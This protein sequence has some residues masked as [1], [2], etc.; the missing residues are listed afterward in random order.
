MNYNDK[1]LQIIDTAEG[2]FADKGFDGTSVRDI[3]EVAGI[4]VAMISY[5]FGSK[6]KLMEALFE[7][8]IER[9]KD[10][11][12]SLLKDETLT[13]FQKVNIM[14]DEQIERMWSGQR[15]YKIMLCEQLIDTNPS[16]TRKVSE[17]KLR[18][19]ELVNKIVKDGQEKGVF[20]KEVDVVL[21]L[22]TMIGTSWQTLVSQD[23]YKNFSA[24]DMSLTDDAYKE[25]M[26]TKLSNHV[27]TLFKIILSYE[28]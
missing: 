20:K 21:M 7:I 15:F 19:A 13:P 28:A 25:Q 10:R 5:Y 3:A 1:Q 8:K 12:E 23:Y 18:N 11:L 26:K 24:E 9:I 27:K 6:E 4:N 14:I 22:N 2:L 16:I 17:L